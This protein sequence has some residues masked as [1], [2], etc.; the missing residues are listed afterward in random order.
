[1]VA[2]A[3]PPFSARE[4]HQIAIFQDFCNE[5]G[6]CDTFCPEDGGPHLEKPRFFGSLEAFRRWRDRD[7]FLVE[8]A[9]TGPPGE[10][11]EGKR[12]AVRARVGGREY[13]LEVDRALG[14]AVFTD[15]KIRL[16]VDHPRRR[17]LRATALAGA[18]EGHVLDA[19]AYLA[20]AVA[21]DGVLDP[22]RVNPVNAR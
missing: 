19:S 3:G 5:C 4:H 9:P 21:V 15:G 22:S 8:V 18:D 2:D 13:T 7:G 11:P 12:V 17:V 14:T 20:T 1:V 16:E 6:N 10:G